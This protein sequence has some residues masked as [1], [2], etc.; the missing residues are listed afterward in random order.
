MQRVSSFVVIRF[1]LEVILFERW[2]WANT[3][4]MEYRELVLF[5]GIGRV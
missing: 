1:L 5:L 2:C 3:G 4:L